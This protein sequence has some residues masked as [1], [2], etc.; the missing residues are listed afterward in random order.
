MLLQ[1]NGKTYIDIMTYQGNKWKQMET[2]GN[3][4][5]QKRGKKGA[6]RFIAKIVIVNVVKNK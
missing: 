3:K 2:N 1:I 6:N 5:K 4:W